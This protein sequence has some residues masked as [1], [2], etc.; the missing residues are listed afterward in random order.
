MSLSWRC[1][2]NPRPPASTAKEQAAVSSLPVNRRSLAS[3]MA[4]SISRRRS[5][6]QLAKK[7]GKQVMHCNEYKLC[8]NEG[9]HLRYLRCGREETSVGTHL[10]V[11][12]NLATCPDVSYFYW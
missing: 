7:P 4:G 5:T 10:Q 11:G 2:Q 12:S 3:Y 8:R 9:A 6:L 1:L